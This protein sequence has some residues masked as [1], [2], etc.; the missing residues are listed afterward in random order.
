M[1]FRDGFPPNYSYTATRTG[2]VTVLCDSHSSL[3]RNRVNRKPY[4]RC[5][6]FFH[7]VVR[8]AQRLALLVPAGPQALHADTA[9]QFADVR[10]FHGG[11]ALGTLHRAPS[12][13]A[14]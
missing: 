8:S 4:R 2:S 3:T 5:K 13:T 6:F 7:D 11:M 9:W 1:G 14:A 12:S 10:H